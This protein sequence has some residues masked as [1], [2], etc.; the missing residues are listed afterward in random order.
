VES[1]K[2]MQNK[3]KQNKTKQNETDFPL[4]FIF[5]PSQTTTTTHVTPSYHSASAVGLFLFVLTVLGLYG[6]LRFFVG[7][8]GWKQNSK[9]SAQHKEDLM[10]MARL[11]ATL[12]VIGRWG[13]LQRVSQSVCEGGGGSGGGHVGKNNNNSSNPPPTH[14]PTHTPI[15]LLS[16]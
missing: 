14:P 6:S 10:R 15:S 13:W 12:G 11:S 9:T 4:T 7:R 2:E 16:T 8:L 3:A 5:P 1:K